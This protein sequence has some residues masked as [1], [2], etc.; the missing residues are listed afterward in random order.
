LAKAEFF[1]AELSRDLAR[2][3]ALQRETATIIAELRMIS[4]AAI[5]APLKVIG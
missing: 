4:A 5:F 1:A 3:A 2:C